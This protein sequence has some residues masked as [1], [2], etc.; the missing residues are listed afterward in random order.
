MSR[1]RSPIG[2]LNNFS[3]ERRGA[4]FHRCPE[5]YRTAPSSSSS[6][7]SSSLP[8]GSVRGRLARSC[9]STPNELP[10]YTGTDREL[11]RSS[12]DDDLGRYSTVLLIKQNICARSGKVKLVIAK[13]MR[14]FIRL[15][16]SPSVSGRAQTRSH[17]I[18]GI[19]FTKLFETG[20]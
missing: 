16:T 20:K 14:R 11:Q 17:D 8:E 4:G 6:S 12:L 18:R 3:E 7:S 1:S 2:N 13:P 15:Q 10:R 19:Q 9:R 5:F